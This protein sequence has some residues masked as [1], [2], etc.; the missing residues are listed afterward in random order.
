MFKFVE[1]KLNLRTLVKRTIID[2]FQTLMRFSKLIILIRQ[3]EETRGGE[4]LELI[5]ALNNTESD[6]IWFFYNE[7]IRLSQMLME[8]LDKF[9]VRIR[10]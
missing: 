3:K 10:S 4:Y 5:Y 2:K 7:N 8:F 9:G 6:K 1:E